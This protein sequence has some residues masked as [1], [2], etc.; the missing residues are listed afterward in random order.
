MKFIKKRI[1]YFNIK[2]KCEKLG[3]KNYKINKNL[4]VDVEGNVTISN[5][6]RLPFNFGEVNGGF[7]C[8]NIGSLVGLPKIINGNLAINSYIKNIKLEGCTEIVYGDVSLNIKDMKDLIDSPKW[9]G[10]SLYIGSNSKLKSLT[11]S[12]K[13]IGGS[14]NCSYQ[15]L[16]NLIGGPEIVGGD[17]HCN[18]NS[19][20]NLEGSP[21]I[22][23][24]FFNC[25]NNNLTSLKGAPRLVRKSF[26][27]NNNNLRTLEFAPEVGG[28][29]HIQKNQFHEVI[30][31]M[32]QERLK[33]II[34]WGDDYSI[35]DGKKIYFP[36]FS[37]LIKDIKDGYL[38]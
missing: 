37:K 5:I 8:N 15:N 16:K 25:S 35:W 18:N 36:R 33:K 29:I 31:K 1:D 20:S 14:F 38:D 7:Y 30:I 2:L 22:I 13:Q 28:V 21:K 4:T 24:G 23:N 32:N 17:Y 3:L 27:A 11:G 26:N 34:E 9:I 19:L 6:D 12:P 10:G